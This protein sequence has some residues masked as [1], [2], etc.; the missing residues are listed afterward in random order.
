VALSTPTAQ[1]S[2]AGFDFSAVWMIAAG[3]M[4]TLQHAP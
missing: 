2:Y 4:P 3:Q 1:A